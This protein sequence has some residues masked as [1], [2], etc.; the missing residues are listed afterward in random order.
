M[1]SGISVRFLQVADLVRSRG[2]AAQVER[3]SSSELFG[4]VGLLA[5]ISV[6]LKVLQ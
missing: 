3:H 5:V 2:K 4:G 1:Y 6:L